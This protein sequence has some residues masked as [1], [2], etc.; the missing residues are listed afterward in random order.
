MLKVWGRTTSSNVQKVT[1]LAEELGLAYHQ[2][3]IGG[4]FG[5]N[6]EPAYRAL[7]PN[8]LVPTIQD[9]SFTLWE[10]NTICRYLANRHSAHA[11]YPID[12][13]ARADVERWMDWSTSM[14][15]SALFD[16][17]WG[18]IRTAPADR[19]AAA[20]KAS[21]EK[22]TKALGVLDDVLARQ[23]W[24]C[25]SDLTLAEITLG[26]HTYRWMNLPWSQVGY[27]PAALPH[28]ANWYARLAERAAYRK[29]VMNPIV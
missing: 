15:G 14:L 17:F 8:G 5:G 28:V 2:V 29:T 21:G 25:G 18:L 26:I 22:T 3:D 7:N 11:L 27:S 9:G 23:P 12:F 6:Q 24:I 4:P 13:Q 20:I 1:W 19:N 10:S 16:G